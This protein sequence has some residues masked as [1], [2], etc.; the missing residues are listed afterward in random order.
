MLF[1]LRKSIVIQEN[2]LTENKFFFFFILFNRSVNTY[3]D[4]YQRY[5][6]QYL[7]KK[8]TLIPQKILVS[9]MQY[10]NVQRNSTI[11]A[12]CDEA[13]IRTDL[14]IFDLAFTLAQITIGSQVDIWHFQNISKVMCAKPSLKV[15]CHRISEIDHFFLNS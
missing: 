5:L 7:K 12:S 4:Y 15:D 9:F 11:K 1:E 6:C 8:I 14:N 2:S 3:Y 13:I 10:H